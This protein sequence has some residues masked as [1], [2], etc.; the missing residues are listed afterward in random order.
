VTLG[1]KKFLK[2]VTMPLAMPMPG[3]AITELLSR[4]SFAPEAQRSQ[5]EDDHCGRRDEQVDEGERQENL[6]GHAHELIDA[7][8]RQRGPQPDGD[9]DEDVGLQEEPEDAPQRAEETIELRGERPRR[10]P[11]AE[12][13]A[14][15]DAAHD[16]QGDV[17]GEEE[18]AEAHARV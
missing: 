5:L 2:V 4:A 11:A 1:A 9:E 7:D 3:N 6:P 8:A 15:Q 18:E 16:E 13:E 12:E 10:Q 17:L 14:D